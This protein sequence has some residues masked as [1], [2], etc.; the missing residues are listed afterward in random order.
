[1]IDQAACCMAVMTTL[2]SSC[3]LTQHSFRVVL[4]AVNTA[5]QYSNSPS[6]CTTLCP[7]MGSRVIS[8][9]IGI[10]STDNPSESASEIKRA[11]SSSDNY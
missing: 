8:C 5:Q 2:Y 10:D 11:E 7:G 9:D 6:H 3:L 4:P 1:M